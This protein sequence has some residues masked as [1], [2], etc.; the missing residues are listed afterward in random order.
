MALVLLNDLLAFPLLTPS[1]VFYIA[2]L[3]KIKLKPWIIDFVVAAGFPLNIVT[4]SISQMVDGLLFNIVS[5]LHNPLSY[6]MIIVGILSR[7]IVDREFDSLGVQ[8]ED[9]RYEN[10]LSLFTAAMPLL[11]YSLLGSTSPKIY[12]GMPAIGL[13]TW[14]VWDMLTTRLVKIYVFKNI[15]GEKEEWMEVVRLEDRLRWREY[16]PHYV[17]MLLNSFTLT[18]M[19]YSIVVFALQIIPVI[20][21]T[22][23]E[24]LVEVVRYS[25]ILLI[26]LSILVGP[27]QWLFDALDL[28]VYDKRLKIL[29]KASPFK[30]LDEFADLFA[31]LGFILTIRD[32]SYRIT[33]GVNPLDPSAI[34]F[35]SQTA[36]FIFLLY[37]LSM[38]TSS[39][40]ATLLYYRL[41]ITRHIPEILHELNP[42]RIEDVIEEKSQ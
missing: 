41:S 12:I 9:A 22:T 6:M 8:I 17:N 19:T 14:L 40:L 18:L 2:Y 24:G 21:I 38:L 20:D 23:I 26:L 5:F 42:K 33:G 31:F 28:R 10:V 32:I 27:S 16:K 25:W 4:F 3:S 7:K 37:W 29:E 36:L 30:Y 15:R 35:A 34:Y 11:F 13:A 1:F 39:L